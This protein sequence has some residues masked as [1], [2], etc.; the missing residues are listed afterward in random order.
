MILIVK[1][2]HSLQFESLCSVRNL[3]NSEVIKV[4]LK[5]IIQD[6][7]DTSGKRRHLGMISLMRT[8][9]LKWQRQQIYTIHLASELNLSKETRF[10]S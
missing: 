1:D 6:Y 4:F 7:I 10:T 3:V 5:Q 8:Y 2:E 9:R